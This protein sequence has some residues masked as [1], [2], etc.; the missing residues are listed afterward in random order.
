MHEELM[1]EAGFETG[2]YQ[3]AARRR[4]QRRRRAGSIGSRSLRLLL[5]VFAA[6]AFVDLFGLTHFMPKPVA[7]VVSALAVVAAMGGHFVGLGQWLLV[8]LGWIDPPESESPSR[9]RERGER[10]ELVAS[11]ADHGQPVE[12]L[13]IAEHEEDPRLRGISRRELLLL[14]LPVA[15]AGDFLAQSGWWLPLGLAG[16]VSLVAYVFARASETELRSS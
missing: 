15:I 11:L 5:F 13:T 12:S 4:E 1:H 3:A 14:P 8:R 2:Y 16:L 9:R 6:A 7:G 10:A